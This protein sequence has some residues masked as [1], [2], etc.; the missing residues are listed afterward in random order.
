MLAGGV[1]MTSRDKMSGASKPVP[2]Q[3]GRRRKRSDAGYE[4]WLTGQL[5]EMYDPVL[6]EPVPEE[7]ERLLGAFEPRTKANT[8]KP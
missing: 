4:R 1:V 6:A 2:A 3:P 7:L 5:H 8:D